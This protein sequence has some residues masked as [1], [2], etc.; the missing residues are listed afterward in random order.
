MPSTLS[1]NSSFDDVTA[2]IGTDIRNAA[3]VRAALQTV[4]NRTRFLFDASAS[5]L[6]DIAALK[7]ISSPA[8]GLVR[9]VKKYGTFV[10]DAGSGAAESLPWIVAP[11]AGSGRWFIAGASAHASRSVVAPVI[12]CGIST[13]AVAPGSE[14]PTISFSG[15]TAVKL[16]YSTSSAYFSATNTGSSAHHGALVNLNSY[17]H[18][19]ATLGSAVL[20]LSGVSPEHANLPAVKPSFGLWRFRHADGVSEKL[21]SSPVSG[22][23]TDAPANVAAYETPHDLTFTPDQNNVIDR[24]LY[25]YWAAVYDEG[26]ADAAFGG[27][28]FFGIKLNFTNIVDARFP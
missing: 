5:A 18:D 19:G 22:H 25:S 11:S 15:T 21:L 26:G 8:D 13:A 1:D 4:A 27:L 2:P 9:L 16:S 28:L 7:A 24:S 3:S 6:P 17:M 10:F 20:R 14:S 12:A 23:V